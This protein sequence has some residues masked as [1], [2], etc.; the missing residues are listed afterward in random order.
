MTGGY[1]KESSANCTK[2]N[3]NKYIY[4]YLINK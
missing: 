1:T 4:L 3:I 2:Y